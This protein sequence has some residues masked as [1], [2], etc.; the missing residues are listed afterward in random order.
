MPKNDSLKPWWML[1]A[2]RANPWWWAL[3]AAVILAL[4]YQFALDARAPSGFVIPTMLAAWYSGPWAAAAVAIGMAAA[5]AG[6]ILARATPDALTTVLL[7][8][9]ALRGGIILLI[10][11]WFARLA[12]HERA[13][14]G[15]VRTLE[16]LL[17]I[18]SFCKNIRN[19]AGQWE[20]LESFIAKRSEARF[21]HGLCPDCQKTHFSEFA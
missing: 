19:D 2:G 4:D 14:E 6:F 10:G 21:S 1:P 15:R 7:T 9:N 5:Q 3:F 18:C 16:G 13:L 12:D 17:P 11:L 8:L 20:R